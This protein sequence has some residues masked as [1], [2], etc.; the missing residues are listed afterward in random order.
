MKLNR[1][2]LKINQFHGKHNILNGETCKNYEKN[3]QMEE[4]NKNIQ[5]SEEKWRLCSNWQGEVF[6]ECLNEIKW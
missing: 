1:T 5:H 6:D 2:K 3:E 4:N